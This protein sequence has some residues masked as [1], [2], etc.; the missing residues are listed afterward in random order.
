LIDFSKGTHWKYYKLPVA[1]YLLIVNSAKEVVLL[2]FSSFV[3]LPCASS[4]A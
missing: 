1:R 2:L 4:G 3:F